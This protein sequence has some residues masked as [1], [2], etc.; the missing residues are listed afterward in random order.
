MEIVSI[1]SASVTLGEDVALNYYV[2]MADGLENVTMNFTMNGEVYDRTLTQQ[3]DGRYKVSLELPP[4]YMANVIKV[5]L[6]VNEEVVET[7][8]YSIKQYA[9]SKLSEVE[10]SD[11]LKQLLTDMLYYGAAAQT[12]KGYNTENHVLSL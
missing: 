12:Y 6:I 5:D 10:S 2:T 3:T 11:E 1:N 4:Q 9:Q 8:D 7:M